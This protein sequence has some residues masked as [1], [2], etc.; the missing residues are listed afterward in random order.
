MKNYIYKYRN[1]EFNDFKKVSYKSNK[2]LVVN[3]YKDAIIVPFEFNFKNNCQ[4]SHLGGVIDKNNQYI[5]ESAF[6]RWSESSSE[7]KF[8]I[9]DNYQNAKKIDETVMY[10]GYFYTHWGHFLMEMTG[11]LWYYI[12]IGWI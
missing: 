11:R 9:E 6:Y 3:E 2:K 5:P 1:A 7:D 4:A 12:Q 10:G 8:V